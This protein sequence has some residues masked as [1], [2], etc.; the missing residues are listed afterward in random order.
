MLALLD[1][2][3]KEKTIDEDESDDPDELSDLP[4]DDSDWEE[5]D[6]DDE[7]IIYVK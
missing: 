3:K 7:G 2:I 6:P 5:D 1:K 4:Q